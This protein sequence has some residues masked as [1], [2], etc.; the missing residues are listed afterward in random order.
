MNSSTK[1]VKPTKKVV[2]TTKKK[3]IKKKD[4]TECEEP[5][6]PK[7]SPKKKLKKVKAPENVIAMNEE[8]DVVVV[9]TPM[10]EEHVSDELSFRL[11]DYNVF[12]S[13]D[14]LEDK[15]FMIRMFGINEKGET[16]CANVE[17][18]KPF[19]YVKIDDGW[20][21]NVVDEWVYTEIKPGMGALYPQLEYEI[22]KHKQLY[23]FTG[24]KQFKFVKFQF[25]S[26]MAYNRLKNLWF[27][28]VDVDT[29]QQSKGSTSEEKKP[30]NEKEKKSNKKSD[31]IR[32]RVNLVFRNYEIELYESNIPPLL[33]YFHVNKISP[34]G[35]ITMNKK[36]ILI[37]G[38][39]E[40]KSSCNVECTAPVEAIRPD[41]AKETRVPYKICSFDIEASS[42]HGDF[43]LPRKTYKRLATN[44]AD[45]FI[46]QRKVNIDVGQAKKI[47]TKCVLKAFSMNKY[48][49]QIDVVYPKK[50][51]TK[52]KVEELINSITEQPLIDML[53]TTN[54]L[55]EQLMMTDNI[56]EQASQLAKSNDDDD[57]GG[58]VVMDEPQQQHQVVEEGG[59]RFNL[60]KKKPKVKVAK[61]TLLLQFLLDDKYSRQENIDTLN[62]LLSAR[63][64]TLEGDKVTFIGSTFMNY[65]EKECNFQHCLVLGDCGKVDNCEIECADTEKDLL[66]RWTRL[67]QREDPDIIIGYNIFGFDYEF[68]FRRAQ[69]NNCAS[70]FLQCSR[71]KEHVSVRDQNHMNPGFDI[72][73]TKIQIASGEYD[74][75]YYNMLG[76]LQI[77]MYSYFRRDYNLSSY[78][79]DDV[80]GQFISD[81]IKDVECDYDGE[82]EITKL[83][84]SN[85][86]GLNKGDYI[87]IEI[88]SFT[89][90]YY[91]NG[92]KFVV[93]NIEKGVEKDGKK[94]NVITISG[95]H[96]L[97]QKKKLKWGMAKDD[98]SPQDI[99]RLANGS[100]EDKAI[101][102]KYCI[103]D[104]NLVHHLMNKI[105]VI[106]GYT[107]M[108]NICSVPVNFLI[109]RGQGIKLTSF[110]AKKCMEKN[111][112]MPD[113]EKPKKEEGYE[114]A[115]VLP[116]KC[117]IYMDNPVACVDYSSLYPSSMISQNYSHD[118]K[119]WSIEYDLEGNLLEHKTQGVRNEKGEFIYDNLPGYEY[120]DIEFDTY[121]YLPKPGS[122]GTKEKVKV[123]KKKCRWAQLPENQLSIMPSILTELLKARKDTRK[124]IKTES[125]PFMQ[126]ILDKRQLGYK[127]TANSLY[128]QCGARTSTFYE[129]DVAAST[130]ATGRMMIIYARLIIEKVYGNM[131][132]NVPDYG[133]VRTKAEYVYGDTDSV[134]FTFN[135]ETPEGDKIVGQKALEL[136]IILAQEAGALSS[137]YLKPPMDLEYEKTFMPFILLSKK[138]YVGMLY[139]EDP[140]KGSMKYMGLSLK[141]RDSCDYLKDVYGGILTILMKENSIAA[142]IN[143]LQ[144]SLMNLADGKV[145]MDKLTITK[146]LRSDYKNPQQIGHKVLADRIG[147]RDPGNKPKPG[148]RIKFVFVVNDKPGALMGEKIEIPSY[149]IENNVQ[150]DFNHYITNQLMK[151]LQQLFGL[152]VKEIWMLQNKKSAI[153]TFEKDVQKLEQDCGDDL[154][155]FM[156]KREKMTNVKV[157]ALLFDKTLRIIY[158]RKHK[159]QTMD[160]CFAKMGVKK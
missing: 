109:F 25:D 45:V 130:T 23:G 15:K 88:T 128:G 54:P 100:N 75:R 30:T 153:K 48:G 99:F 134:F 49:E 60:F 11:L 110:V 47:F 121:E 56:F 59:S 7:K 72:M 62:E 135:L 145:S 14:S 154:E 106:T 80:A 26:V 159:I 28:Y 136:T 38:D 64:P 36:Q 117:S 89:T 85:L 138:R 42:S 37:Y 146:A 5:P 107:E 102:A 90:D 34:T 61:K 82:Q 50:M 142:A 156:K 158:N 10:N 3:V 33:R 127:V 144:E 65:G 132:I 86:M 141:R 148:D 115:I 108:S 41:P 1:E 4:I 113:L 125:D 40:K 17:N 122:A 120:I 77:D 94:Y 66:L 12:D 52:E 150:I 116:P 114:G 152:A 149:I 2:T 13:D 96:V 81:S 83:Y 104:C 20:N 133:T 43:P 32:K 143:Y 21:S 22:V 98:L 57:G 31:R 137:E 140:H 6:Q 39:E 93:R 124:R 73:N 155:V 147:L 8:T 29:K 58:G 101:V 84:S 111:T 53:A 79:L 70:E 18:F 126:N 24:G 87:H 157:K 55:V 68:M 129:Q 123:G 119:V 19:F 63:F 51:P 67:I 103:Q 160:E 139:E 92:E 78:K 35:W 46:Q 74:L 112:L 91:N 97:D 44:I 131:L 27:Q 16:L 9:K 95:H 69:E 118:S 105:D 71:I 76:R 151:P